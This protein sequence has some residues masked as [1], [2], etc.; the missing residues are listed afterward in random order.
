MTLLVVIVTATL[1]TTLVASTISG[2]RATQFDQRFT[3]SLTGG[4]AGVQQALFELNTGQLYGPP[5]ATLGPFTTAVDGAEATWTASRLNEPGN[6]WQVVSEGATGGVTRTVTSTIRDEPLFPLA[7]FA[8]ESMNLKGGNV[9]DSYDSGQPACATAYCAPSWCTPRLGVVGANGTVE[10]SGASGG[11]CWAGGRSVDAIH[12]HDW[13][14]NPGTG[15]SPTDPGGNRCKHSGGPN[16][17][18]AVWT[19][20]PPLDLTSSRHQLLSDRVDEC[21]SQPLADHV[22]MQGDPPLDPSTVHCFASLTLQRASNN[23]QITLGG[24]AAQPL[25]VYVRDDLKSERQVSVNCPSGGCVPGKSVPPASALQI[26]VESGSVLMGNDSAFVGVI[27]AP[28]A[29]CVGNPSSA[30]VDYY[31]ALVCASIGGTQGGWEFHYDAALA[32]VSTGSYAV[33]SWREDS[34]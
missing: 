28:N 32:G 27:Y 14:A 4:D 12:L 29:S 34:P 21:R 30:Q 3:Q 25:I 15:A 8:D 1:A 22:V 23:T 18:S 5:G 9:V 24:S 7:A 31:G 10:F 19:L 6:Q 13:A 33:S 26:F 11:P 20:D 2:Q 17:D 16:C